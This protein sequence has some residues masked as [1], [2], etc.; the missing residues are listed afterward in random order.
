[1]IRNLIISVAVALFIFIGGRLAE[2]HFF[3]ER[4]VV[5]VDLQKLV[6]EEIQL[7]A[8]KPMTEQD[9]KERSQK[10][11]KAFEKAL[12]DVSAQSNRLVLVAP[13]VV[14]GA[15]DYTDRV[16]DDLKSIMGGQGN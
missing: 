11:S 6:N 5:A 13:A 15:A 8:T 10:F 9:R 3:P 1:M 16:R 4:E 2:R 7:N 12:D 14:G